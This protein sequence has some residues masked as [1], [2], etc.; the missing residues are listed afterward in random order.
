M[1]T[2]TSNPTVVSFK[3]PSPLKKSESR[4][5]NANANADVK[6]V[7]PPN[8]V[9]PL[10]SKPYEPMRKREKKST[11]KTRNFHPYTC[12]SASRL[13]NPKNSTWPI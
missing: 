11:Q 6:E 5:R 13:C 8:G 1:S 4:K 12:F 10:A 9:L 2:S 7:L 3:E